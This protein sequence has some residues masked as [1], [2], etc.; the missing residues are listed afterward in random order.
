MGRQCSEESRGRAQIL[1]E[2]L[3]NIPLTLAGLGLN[4]QALSYLL[5][6]IGI[7]GN[8]AFLDPYIHVLFYL[9]SAQNVVFSATTS[10]EHP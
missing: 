5:P 9:R 7:W 10:D 3:A 2:M 1:A 8:R 4:D 6:G